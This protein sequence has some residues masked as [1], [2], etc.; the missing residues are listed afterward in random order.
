[1]GKEKSKTDIL[2][3]DLFQ[4]VFEHELKTRIDIDNILEG[5]RR[6]LIEKLEAKFNEFALAEE[7]KS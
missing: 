3:N 5:R 6:E 1:M 4:M 2:D 7:N